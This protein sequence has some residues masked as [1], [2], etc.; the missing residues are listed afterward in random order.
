MKTVNEEEPNEG[1]S[2]PDTTNNGKFV[3]GNLRCKRAHMEPNQWV[4]GEGRWG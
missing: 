2:K 1:N 3:G 4:F